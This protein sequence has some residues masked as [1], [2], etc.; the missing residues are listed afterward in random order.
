[1]QEARNVVRITSVRSRALYAAEAFRKALQLLRKAESMIEIREQRISLAAEEKA[2]ATEAAEDARATAEQQKEA[3][4]VS[5]F[6]P[7]DWNG[8]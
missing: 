1:M 4:I 2:R 7:P 8:Q 5:H 6:L 3:A